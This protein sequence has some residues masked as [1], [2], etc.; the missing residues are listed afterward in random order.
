MG[1]VLHDRCCALRWLWRD[2]HSLPS[3]PAP[4]PPARPLPPARLEPLHSP[5][6]GGRF[7]CFQWGAL[8]G[9]HSACTAGPGGR[10]ESVGDQAVAVS[11]MECSLKFPP[12][13]VILIALLRTCG[14]GFHDLVN[15]Q[16]IELR[17]KGIGH[18]FWIERISV[19]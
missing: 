7:P 15:W 9:A 19:V 17:L 13:T 16:K 2:S 5:C 3:P 8:W 18:L 4:A 1:R 10:S 11:A 6:R 14:V 12:W